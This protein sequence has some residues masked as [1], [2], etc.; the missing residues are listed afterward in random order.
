MSLSKYTGMPITEICTVCPL[1][2]ALTFAGVVCNDATLASIAGVSSML[3]ATPG[4]TVVESIKSVTTSVVAPVLRAATRA[5]MVVVYALFVRIEVAVRMAAGRE[6]IVIE[7][8]P[9]ADTARL[10]GKLATTT[11]TVAPPYE[12]IHEGVYNVTAGAL[13]ETIDTVAVA[14]LVPNCTDNVAGPSATEFGMT[15]LSNCGDPPERVAPVIVT[16]AT[17]SVRVSPDAPA[18]VF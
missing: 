3:N 13:A 1:V 17:V 5:V 4:T 6:A 10:A 12:N 7:S 2:P 15:K 9:T 18:G 14:A 16:P 8:S 11:L